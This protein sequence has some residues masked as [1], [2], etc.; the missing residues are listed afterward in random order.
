MP[1]FLQDLNLT[2][3][4]SGAFAMWVFSAFVGGMPPPREFSST[5]YVWLYRSLQ[6]FAANINRARGGRK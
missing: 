1:D 3:L 5:G 6:L 4:V 2:E